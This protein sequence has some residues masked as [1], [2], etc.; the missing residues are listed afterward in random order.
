MRIVKEYLQSIGFKKKPDKKILA[1]VGQQY[2]NIS[3]KDSEEQVKKHIDAMLS[4]FPRYDTTLNENNLDLVVRNRNNKELIGIFE[5]KRLENK[6]EMLEYANLNK[7][8]LGEL[9]V[10]FKSLSD[11]NE[12]PDWLVASNGKEWFIFSKTPF[13]RF[14]ENLKVQNHFG[15]GLNQ[16]PNLVSESRGDFYS[17][18]SSFLKNNPEILLDF[19]KYCLYTNEKESI[20]YFL[21]PDLFLHEYNPNVGNTLD[22]QFYKELLYLFGLEEEDNQG[23]KTIVPNE[24]KNA[25]YSQISSQLNDFEQ[26]LELIVI[27]LNR[28]LFLKLFEARL[29]RFNNDDLSFKFLNKKEIPD[30]TT[31]ETL[32]F[33]ILAVPE[34][35]R[36]DKTIPYLNSSLFEK[37]PREGLVPISSI[38]G[39]GDV[40]YSKD[41][42]LKEN[43]GNRR[44][45]STTLL[46]YLFEFLDAYD[47]ED[48]QNEFSLISPVVLSQVHNVGVNSAFGTDQVRQSIGQCGAVRYGRVA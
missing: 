6:M 17:D 20:Y 7:K 40:E 18:V 39:N 4:A 24:V 26:S 37:K 13:V 11:K 12:I 46:E 33:S 14:W 44:T 30:T 9:I 34:K 15:S 19:S 8:A 48:D 36:T 22:K 21:S 47:F 27:W 35:E 5:C 23:R 38:R 45:G 1:I 31:L 3:Q 29:V 43:N 10:N 32:F 25:F 28:I 42:I 2:D 16:L 41:T